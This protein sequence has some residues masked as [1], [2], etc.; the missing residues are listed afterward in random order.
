MLIFS[1]LGSYLSEVICLVAVRLSYDKSFVNLDIV[2]LSA[3]V[4][5]HIII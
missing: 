3:K 5:N 4:K 2:A 1:Q